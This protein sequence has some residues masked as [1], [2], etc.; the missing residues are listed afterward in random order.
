MLL[1]AGMS[2]PKITDSARL[3]FCP[4]G[5][6]LISDASYWE[7]TSPPILA[8]WLRFYDSRITQNSGK[9]SYIYSVI[10]ENVS[11]RNAR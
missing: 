8:Y 6:R 3:S 1:G 10:I 2:H 4:S 9:C 7:L 11:Q 5:D